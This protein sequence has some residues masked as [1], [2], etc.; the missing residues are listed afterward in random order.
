MILQV[1]ADRRKGVKIICG[2]GAA[3]AGA[4][5]DRQVPTALAAADNQAVS[6]ATLL[7][8]DWKP[9]E[10]KVEMLSSNAEV[11]KCLGLEGPVTPRA[12]VNKVS[13]SCKLQANLEMA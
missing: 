7:P 12:F 11:C 3:G 6:S 2:A 8:A 13:T 4:G 10:L 5:A 1:S 9:L